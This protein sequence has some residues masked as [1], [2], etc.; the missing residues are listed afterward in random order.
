MR[1]LIELLILGGIPGIV[2]GYVTNRFFVKKT[3]SV[4]HYDKMRQLEQENQELDQ[5]NAEQN[6]IKTKT[7][8]VI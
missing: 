7:R 4:S 5:W 2:A 8:K 1:I 6:S 3:P